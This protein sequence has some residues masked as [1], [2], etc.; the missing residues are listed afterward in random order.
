MPNKKTLKQNKRS[1]NRK[2]GFFGWFKSKPKS[3]S[4]KSTVESTPIEKIKNDSDL[5]S[6]SILKN[7]P[8]FIAVWYSLEV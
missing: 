2:G 6:K 1:R 3:D 8:S 4:P 7:D 5:A